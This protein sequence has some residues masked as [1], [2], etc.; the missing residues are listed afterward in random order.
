MKL[1]ITTII[2][3]MIAQMIK[4]RRSRRWREPRQ[5]GR[6]GR[7]ANA[8]RPIYCDCYNTSYTS[9]LVYLDLYASTCF[10]HVICLSNSFYAV[11]CYFNSF[12]LRQNRRM[13]LKGSVELSLWELPRTA[14]ALLFE[15]STSNN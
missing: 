12:M 6:G 8:A 10:K 2:V 11:S 4:T 5:R 7:H 3:I 15:C 13:S 14:K 1:M 9:K